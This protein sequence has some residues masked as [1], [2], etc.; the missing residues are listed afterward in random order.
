MDH[1]IHAKTFKSPIVMQ[2]LFLLLEYDL[3]YRRSNREDRQTEI[4][5]NML[6]R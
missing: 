1:F 2:P 3:F 5:K 4:L 6:F